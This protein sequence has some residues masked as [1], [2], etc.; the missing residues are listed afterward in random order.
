MS[1]FRRDALGNAGAEIIF[2]TNYQ[3]SRTA[4]RLLRGS[5]SQDL[6]QQLEQLSVGLRVRPRT[7]TVSGFCTGLTGLT[8]Q[9]VNAGISFAE[10][11]RIL[12]ADHQPRHH[13]GEDDAWNIAALVLHLKAKGQWALPGPASSA[14]APGP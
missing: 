9:E 3:K 1:A 12:I 8:Q 5:D 11:C 7:P 6:S 4:A 13:R 10:A 2:R 14:A